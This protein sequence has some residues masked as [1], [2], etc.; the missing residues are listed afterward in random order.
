MFETEFEIFFIEQLVDALLVGQCP[1]NLPEMIILALII[2]FALF[3]IWIGFAWDIGFSGLFG[4]I[5]LLISTWYFVA[6]IQLLAF[7]VAM[8]AIV[9]LIYFPLK[10]FFVNIRHI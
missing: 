5:I 3:F 8:L 2:G 4:S 1:D 10:G 7:A 6:C 9:L